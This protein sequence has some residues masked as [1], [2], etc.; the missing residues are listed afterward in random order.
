MRNGF[1]HPIRVT[2]DMVLIDGR[3][4]L[5][6]AWALSLDPPMEKFNPP[7]VVAYIL[8]EN[9]IRRHL[10]VGQRAMIAEKLANLSVGRPNKSAIVKTDHNNCDICPNYSEEKAAEELGVTRKDVGRARVIR[11]YAGAQEIAAVERGTKTLNEVY[12]KARKKKLASPAPEK[13]SKNGAQGIVTLDGILD[14]KRIEVPYPKPRG[15]HQFNQASEAVDWASWTWNPVAGCLHGCKYC[16]ARE[17]AYRDSYAAAYPI[18]FAPLF[19]PERLDDPINTNPGTERAQ[20]GRVF[21]C[22][23][24]DLMG[25]E[26]RSPSPL[27]ALER[28]TTFQPLL[29]SFLI[30]AG[31]R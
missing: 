4:R 28:T 5:Q 2:D 24:A 16:Y 22:S 23:M 8:S 26:M 7:D 9:M 3:N 21:V 30:R 11:E 31:Q 6:A 12:R 25:R 19:H 20:D 17:M 27:P 1:L 13:P 29:R 15:L 10:T 14:K 18:K